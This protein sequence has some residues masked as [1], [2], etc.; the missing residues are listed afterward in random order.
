M[1]LTITFQSPDLSSCIKLPLHYNYALQGFI[2]NHISSHLAEFLH[3]R[4]YS[5]ERRV[6]KLFTFS[7]I[8]GRYRLDK[9]KRLIS[10]SS[11][12]KFQLSSPLD[13]F[14]QEFAETL[15][16]SPDVSLEGNSLVV[17]SIEVHFSPH[18]RSPVIIKMLSPLT[19]Y[20]TFLTGEG[21][22]KTYY[23]SPFEEEFSRIVKENIVKKYV[24]FHQKKPSSEDFDILPLKVDKKSEK[25]V[26]YTPKENS[27]TVI[28]GWM[29]I[30]K[31][32]GSPELIHLAYDAGLGAKNPQG[33]GMFEIVKIA[34]FKEK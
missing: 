15:A 29:G 12:V 33:F 27:P 31:L 8:F 5:F 23:F 28:K 10:F 14:I 3:N 1:R 17:S 19:C 34:D 32:K 21:K 9:E 6:F 22:K 13:D 2:Y 18:I 11:P 26:K 24:A 16:R 7:R 20:S 4:G 30:Y 25:I